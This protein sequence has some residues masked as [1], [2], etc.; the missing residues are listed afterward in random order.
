[1]NCLMEAKPTDDIRAMWE[2]A[3]ADELVV[4]GRLPEEAVSRGSDCT[5]AYSSAMLQCPPLFIGI[6]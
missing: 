4:I 5:S 1:M 6:W 3:R 2:V